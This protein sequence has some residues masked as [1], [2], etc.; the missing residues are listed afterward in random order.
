[1]DLAAA[2][3]HRFFDDGQAQAGTF[4]VIHIGGPEEGIED[5][6]EIGSGDARALIA[7]RED[8]APAIAGDAQGDATALG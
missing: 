3:Y 8:A 4:A 7:H 6:L 1:M 5:L 2:L